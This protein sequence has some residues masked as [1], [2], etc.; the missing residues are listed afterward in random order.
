MGMEKTVFIF[1]LL[2]K[3]KINGIFS[4]IKQNKH[5]LYRLINTTFNRWQPFIISNG[6]YF[7][8]EYYMV[9]LEVS[10]L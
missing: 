3:Q 4:E 5:A 1:S 9:S 10:D 6:E 2:M 7:E 8:I